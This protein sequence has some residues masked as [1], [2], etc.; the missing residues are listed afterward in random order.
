MSMRQA[1]T[2]CVATLLTA[3]ASYPHARTH[4]ADLALVLHKPAEIRVFAAG[5]SP[6]RLI[7]RRAAIVPPASALPGA[8]SLASLPDHESL[9]V[10][11]WTWFLDCGGAPDQAKPREQWAR[12]MLSA[13]GNK[14]AKDLIAVALDKNLVIVAS[15]AADKAMILDRATG[16]RLAGTSCGA[17]GSRVRL[18]PDR[19]RIVLASKGLEIDFDVT[20]RSVQ[21]NGRSTGEQSL[22]LI[23]LAMPEPL[24]ASVTT[25]DDVLDVHLPDRGD[26]QAV[27]AQHGGAWSNP[28]N[29]LFALGGHA[30][31]LS[32]V[33]LR[34]YT[35][36]GAE[37]RTEELA[38]RVALVSARFCP[39]PGCS[40]ESR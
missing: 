26:W 1:G 32:T 29:W 12:T 34:T 17:A 39:Q 8:V 19:R 37:T 28:A 25:R 11:Y 18:S 23:D 7:Q 40:G 31:R 13:A 3:A 22:Q 36:K 33:R 16:Q 9:H 21:W 20:P 30:E 27:T 15:A 14:Q 4:A 5:E 6:A 38:A 2:W 10:A 24:V 35:G